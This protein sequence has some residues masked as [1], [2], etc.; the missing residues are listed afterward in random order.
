[1]ADGDAGYITTT[2][3]DVYVAERW[4]PEI[5]D[6]LYQSMVMRPLVRFFEVPKG[7]DVIHLPQ[8]KKLTAE[9]VTEGTALTG[10]QNT[11]LKFDIT[12]NKQ[13]A[14]PFTISKRAMIQNFIGDQLMREYARRA[15]EAIAYQIDQDLL[16]LYSGL[17]QSIACYSTGSTYGHLTDAYIRQGVKYLDEAGAP[18]DNRFLVITPL[19]KYTLLGLDK[20]TLVQNIG[21]TD[22]IQRGQFGEI[23]GVKVFVTNAIK[24]AT[25]RKNLMFHRDAFGLGIQAP[26]EVNSL[27]D[28]LKVAWDVVVDAIYG[29]SELRDDH[30]VAL[31]TSAT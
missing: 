30:A 12:M 14:V 8:M 31:V 21:S 5:F 6:V 10:K 23:Y 11:E 4:I 29:V 13:Y 2:T 24:T 18:N 25:T 26:P 27:Y 22:P 16:G 3:A 7:V 17:S 9:A 15:G 1:M 20:F 19:E 28:P